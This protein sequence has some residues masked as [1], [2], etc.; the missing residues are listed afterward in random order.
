MGSKVYGCFR[1][2]GARVITVPSRSRDR[3][4]MTGLMQI[5]CPACSGTV[6]VSRKVTPDTWGYAAENKQRRNKGRY[7]E[8]L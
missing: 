6:S 8:K 2:S 3:V 4:G 7:G 5:V 1:C